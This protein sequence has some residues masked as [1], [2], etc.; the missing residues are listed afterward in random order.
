[1]RAEVFIKNR[2]VLF[3]SL[4]I[5]S[6]TVLFSGKAPKKS[7]DEAYPFTVNK[8]FYYLSGLDEEELAIV[9]IKKEGSERALVFVKKP[10]LQMEKWI[11]K[12]IRDE[13]AKEIGGFTEAQFINNLQGFIHSLISGEGLEKVYIDLERDGFG[14]RETIQEEFAKELRDKYPQI[15]IKNIYPKIACLRLVKC[16]EEIEEMKKAIGITIEGVES[17]MQNAKA[18]M[19]EYE[20]EAYYDFTC[21]SKGVKDY[22]FKT[23][24]ATGANATILHYVSND[25]EIKDGDLVLFDLGAKYEHYCA[26]ISRTFPANGKFT[27]RQKAV[28]EAVLTVNEKVIE[29]M[30]PG[31]SFIDVNNQATEWIA[32]ECIKLGLIEDKKDVINYYW[33]S[34]GHSLGLDTHDVGGRGPELKPGMVFTVEPGI[35]IEEEGIGVRIEDDILITEDG[36]ENLTKGMIKTVAEIEAFMSKK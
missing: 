34:I 27:E 15:T 12:S 23:I 1:M 19:K 29:M 25:S 5:N 32:E 22:A 14:S 8:N 21:K 11:G 17:L 33:H 24:A 36:N 28:Y 10:D 16:E 20:L 9:L 30:K 26:D 2:E 3:E 31:V 4:D 13:E 18:K 6:V 35:Y 7:A